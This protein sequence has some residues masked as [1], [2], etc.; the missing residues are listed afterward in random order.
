MGVFG[1]SIVR[2]C[3]RPEY[4]LDKFAV[5]ANR[6]ELSAKLSS[7]IKAR[8]AFTDLIEKYEVFSPKAASVEQAAEMVGLRTPKRV[9]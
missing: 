7:Y 6:P 2:M 9:R 8:R 1:R 3:K 5:K 4:L